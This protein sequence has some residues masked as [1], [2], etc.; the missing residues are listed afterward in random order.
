MKWII[1][2][3]ALWSRQWSSWQSSES[4]FPA[5][6]VASRTMSFKQQQVGDDAAI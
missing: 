2:V 6:R 5:G 3:I 1:G 4:P